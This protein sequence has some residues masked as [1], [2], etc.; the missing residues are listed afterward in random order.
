MRIGVLATRAGVS[1]SSIRFYEARGLLPPP[2]RRPSGYREYDDRA[3]EI[4]LFINRARGLG[5]SLAEIAGHIRS[6]KDDARKS[7]LLSSMERKLSEFDA[8]LADLQN[9]RAALF[10]A[11][12]DLRSR[13]REA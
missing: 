4:I 5:F 9:R 8:L 6:P 7:R 2:K 13:T 3:L 11:I 1:T 10:E 12:E